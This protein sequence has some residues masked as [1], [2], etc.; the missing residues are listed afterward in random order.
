[1]H[2]TEF[3]TICTHYYILMQICWFSNF[4][5]GV[6]DNIQYNAIVDP[7]K[8]RTNNKQLQARKLQWQNSYENLVFRLLCFSA[9][10]VIKS[11]SIFFLFGSPP[12]TGPLSASA[13]I[14]YSYFRYRRKKNNEW[15]VFVCVRR[16]YV[17]NEF[18]LPRSVHAFFPFCWHTD[19]LLGDFFLLLYILQSFVV[20]S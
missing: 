17:P 20:V 16:E 12:L 14:S 13:Q 18:G 5:F 15:P 8:H 19:F 11:Q 1:M 9:A 2:S 3:S 6:A 10:D 4:L 7:E